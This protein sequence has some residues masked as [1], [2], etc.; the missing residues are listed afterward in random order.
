LASTLYFSSSRQ[1]TS[2]FG[3]EEDWSLDPFCFLNV[4]GV[5]AGPPMRPKKE[6]K[7][8][9]VFLRLVAILEFILNSMFLF[10]L[11][12]LFSFQTKTRTKGL[13]SMI[14]RLQIGNLQLSN[15]TT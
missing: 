8:I 7:L 3:V 4:L 2:K 1:E 15:L 10:Q 6:V 11:G 13:C 5:M 9:K 14:A 12:Y